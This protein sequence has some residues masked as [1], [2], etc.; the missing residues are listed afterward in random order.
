MAFLLEHTRRVVIKLGTGILTSGI[1]ELNSRRLADIA[2]QVT[3]LRETGVQ[4]VLVSSGAIGL[5]MGRMGLKRRPH[6]LD[7]L[8]VCAAVGQTLLIENWQ[9]AFRPF[10]LTVGQLLF[11]RD[12]LGG[13]RRHVGALQLFDRMLARGIIPIVNENDSIGT[14]EIRFGD[15]DV[16]SALV[17]T[18]IRANQLIILSRAE[19][20][21]DRNGS[22]AI[23]PVVREFTPEIMAMAE[24]TDDPTGR[25]GMITKL[26]AAKLATR[27][28]CG[29]F[30]GSGRNPE[31]LSHLFAGEPNGTFFIPRRLPMKSI[32]RWLAFFERAEGRIAVDPGAIA[33]L[34][35]KGASLLA[36]GVTG[37]RGRFAARAV[38]DIAGPDGRV[39]AKGITNFSSRQVARIAGLATPDIRKRFPRRK[40]L[41]VIHRDYL[42]LL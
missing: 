22:G 42:V 10:D 4:V 19:G 30:I 38:V 25:G 21:V 23:I 11:T 15:N 7:M 17:A 26:E 40:R 18:L 41:E 34:R 1:G 9:T 12:D 8:Q 6:D 35:E 39:F 32:K 20:L 16:L 27:N 2:A 33:A 24:D 36:K 14:E 29:V 28:G 37:T 5:G 31:I 3:A 13:R